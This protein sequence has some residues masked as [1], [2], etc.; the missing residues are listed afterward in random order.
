[1]CQLYINLVAGSSGMFEY[2]LLL[3]GAG[4]DGC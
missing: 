2:V 1:M 4:D 3:C